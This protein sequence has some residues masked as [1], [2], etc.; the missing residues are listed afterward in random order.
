MRR[1]AERKQR[2]HL[3]AGGRVFDSMRKE[4]FEGEPVVEKADG[5]WAAVRL[6]AEIPQ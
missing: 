5:D 6:L 1:E 2:A 3:L 4:S